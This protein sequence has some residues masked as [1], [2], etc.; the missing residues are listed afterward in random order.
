[1]Y[2]DYQSPFQS[3]GTETQ[4]HTAGRLTDPADSET[5]QSRDDDDDQNVKLGR[6][7][8]DSQAEMIDRNSIKHLMPDEHEKPH[9][10][11]ISQTK[12]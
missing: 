8:Q 7:G 5:K 3:S 4:R 2:K 10:R 9:S 1:M 6:T 12:A 11:H